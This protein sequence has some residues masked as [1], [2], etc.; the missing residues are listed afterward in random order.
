MPHPRVP[1]LRRNATEAERRLWALLRDR[2]LA[3]AKFRRQH[4]IGPYVADFACTKW[5]L[6]VEAD[7]GQHAGSA[8]DRERTGWLSGQGWRVLRFWNDEILGNT[9]GVLTAILAAIAEA[10]PRP[11]PPMGARED[12]EKPSP[13]PGEREDPEK[14]SP[15]PGERGG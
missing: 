1:A 7:G 3:G 8:P 4:P 2:R 12:S 10:S 5:R 13:P 11:S 9:E 14:P 15:P 6:V